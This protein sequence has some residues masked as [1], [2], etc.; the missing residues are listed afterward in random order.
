MPDLPH[1]TD[2]KIKTLVGERSFTLALDYLADG[3]LSHLHRAGR[4]LTACVRGTAAKPYK[5]SIR[6]DA[7][8]LD[9]ADCACPVASGSCK[10]IAAV[11]IAFARTPDAFVPAD[12]LD[13]KLQKLDKPHLIALLKQIFRRD[14]ALENLLDTIPD[15][16][17]PLS[18]DAF[19]AQADDAFDN[20]P[21][22]WGYTGEIAARLRP[23]VET[24]DDFQTANQP[25]NAAAA[26]QGILQSVLA[27]EYALNDDEPGHLF[28]IVEDCSTGLGKCLQKITDP[29]PREPLLQALFN[30]CLFDSDQGG[31]GLADA[32]AT[33]LYDQTIPTDRRAIAAWIHTAQKSATN[34][35]REGLTDMLEHFDS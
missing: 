33:I 35:T 31:T 30:V 23:L 5:V 19:R 9:S 18:P 15:G 21:D 7:T 1:L 12:Q 20:A 24:A 22:D 16:K 13:K 17:K 32:A 26:Y 10:H 3:A 11:L 6:F 34:Y 8:G 28:P 4:T 25:Q 14:P 2:R 27:H 29:A